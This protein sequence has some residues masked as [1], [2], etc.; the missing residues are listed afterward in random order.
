MRINGGYLILRRT[1]FDYL[2]EGD[3]LVT[4]AFTRVAKDGLMAAV[5]YDGYWAPMGTLRERAALEEQY[6]S[7]VSPRTLW[8]EPA[9]DGKRP[10]GVVVVPQGVTGVTHPEAARPMISLGLPTG[11]LDVLCLGAY[12]DDIEIGCGATLLGLA[13]RP[14]TSVLGVVLTGTGDRALEARDALP[15]F[16][17]GAEVEVHGLPDGR[18]PAH[19]DEVK[20]ILE[21][22]GRRRTPNLVLA[23]AA[24]TP[25]RT[26]AC[27]APW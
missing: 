7:G 22:V 18:L 5:P 17:P 13:Q 11:P 24:T 23:P 15:R 6:R 9:S 12:P 20:E 3:D 26:T 25:T 27:W 19:W 8:R 10:I 4:E 1:I 21:D 2:D 14:S 16:V